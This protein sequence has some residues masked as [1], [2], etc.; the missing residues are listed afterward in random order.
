MKTYDVHF[1]S[2][3]RGYVVVEV[4]AQSARDALDQAIADMAAVKRE[5][6]TIA[7]DGTE[8]VVVETV[9]PGR[10]APVAIIR[11]GTV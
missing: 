2:R 10:M 8:H 5:F 9:K 6:R 3:K 4:A 7:D 1:A 11:K